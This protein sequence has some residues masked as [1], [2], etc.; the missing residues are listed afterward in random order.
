MN[1]PALTGYSLSR[2][3]CRKCRVERVYALMPAPRLDLCEPCYWAWQDEGKAG[4]VVT[5]I[6]HKEKRGGF[7]SKWV[8]RGGGSN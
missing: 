7:R 6:R 5:V 1:V 4:E 3:V 8:S 2:P